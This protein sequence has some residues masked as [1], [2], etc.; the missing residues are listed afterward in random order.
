MLPLDESNAIGQSDDD[1][2]RNIIATVLTIAIYS[3]SNILARG[4][5]CEADTENDL[6]GCLGREMIAIKEQRFGRDAIFR[7]DEESGTR[8]IDNPRKPDG[9]I[10]I[11]ITYSFVEAE[12]FGIECKRVNDKGNELAKKYVNK[13]LMRFITGKYSPGHDWMA[14][15]GFVVDGKPTQAI[16]RI[17]GFLAITKRRTRMKREW[18]Q[19]MS[20]GEYEHLY[21]TCHQQR[22]KQTPITVLHLFL[23]VKPSAA[24]VE[25][26]EASIHDQLTNTPKTS[27][28]T[29][30]CSLLTGE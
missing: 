4:E 1:F 27:G 8:S 28:L 15:I 20:F 18:K 9:R 12:Y 21:S 13:G 22:E 5:I 23:T 14:M 19:E 10:D 26:P 29:D 17:C 30:V 7:I 24:L 11:K 6:A 2:L 25:S 16:E 3:W